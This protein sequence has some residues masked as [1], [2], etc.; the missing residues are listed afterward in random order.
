MFPS[1]WILQLSPESREKVVKW[2]QD[3]GLNGYSV[4]PTEE[5]VQVGFTNI[6]DAFRFRMQFDEDLLA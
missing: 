5:A 4:I 2:L 3:E 6:D 1:S